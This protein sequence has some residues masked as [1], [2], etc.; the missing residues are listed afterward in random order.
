MKWTKYPFF[1][2]FCIW[3]YIWGSIAW[4]VLIIFCALAAIATLD[5]REFYKTLDDF[6]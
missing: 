6:I 3:Q 1:I 2:A 4:I 5:Y